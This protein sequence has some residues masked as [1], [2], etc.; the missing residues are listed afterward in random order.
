MKVSFFVAVIYGVMFHKSNG[1][2]TD[3]NKSIEVLGEDFYNEL[4][5]IRHKIKLD[6]ALFGYYDR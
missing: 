3:Q 6:R 2:I 5:H 4:L 1:E